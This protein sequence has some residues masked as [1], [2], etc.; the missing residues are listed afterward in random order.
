MFRP[1]YKEVKSTQ[2][3]NDRMIHLT[4]HEYFCIF[5]IKIADKQTEIL[6]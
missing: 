3:Y 5:R 4:G 6:T 1:H 2:Y